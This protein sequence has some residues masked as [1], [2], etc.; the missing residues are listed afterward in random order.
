M[1]PPPPTVHEG[2]NGGG[3]LQK[4]RVHTIRRGN[5]NKMLVIEKSLLTGF[6]LLRHA[7]SLLD[8]LFAD[9]VGTGWGWGL[10]WGG[11]T[12]LIYP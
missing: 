7:A 6:A 4:T 3:R 12:C 9:G 8:G 2:Q 11:E 1:S 10:G 5:E